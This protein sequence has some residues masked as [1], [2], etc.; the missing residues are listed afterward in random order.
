MLNKKT[1]QIGRGSNHLGIVRLLEEELVQDLDALSE[2][3]GL[4]VQRSVLGER[5]GDREDG[6]VLGRRRP[7][8]IRRRR[9]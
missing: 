2:L 1:K 7:V 6:V 8:A 9:R 3:L 5:G 4:E